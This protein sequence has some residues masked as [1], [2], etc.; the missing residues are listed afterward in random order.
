ME[1]ITGP[2]DSN[3]ILNTHTAAFYS[4]SGQLQ[5]DV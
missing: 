2:S 5:T 3:G 4:I 1:H